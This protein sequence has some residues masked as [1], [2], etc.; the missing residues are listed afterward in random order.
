MS[1]ATPDG[2][3]Q[4]VNNML[5]RRLIRIAHA[6]IDDVFTP[7]SRGFFQTISNTEN[8][9]WQTLDAGEIIHAHE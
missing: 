4:L 3:D 6:E 7:R 8:I 2:L 1:V 5:G 9:G